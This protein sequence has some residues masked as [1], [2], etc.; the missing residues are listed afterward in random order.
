MR[1]N[2]RNLLGVVFTTSA[3]LI[4]AMAW[5]DGFLDVT[6]IARVLV[7]LALEPAIILVEFLAFLFVLKLKWPTALGTSFVAN[8][9]SLA[10]GWYTAVLLS[11]VFS[12]PR[13]LKEVVGLV[14]VLA[15]EVPVVVGMNR[16]YADRRRLVW[17]AVVANV[18]TYVAARAIILGYAP[19]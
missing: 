9:A 13:A 8:A 10:V 3:L 2:G 5:A 11:S 15:V 16:R 1:G 19:D 4:A 18:C 6:P 12:A 14:L 7:G 17:T